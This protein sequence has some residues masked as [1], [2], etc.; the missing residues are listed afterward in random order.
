MPADDGPAG[1]APG[2]CHLDVLAAEFVE[3]RGAGDAGQQAHEGQGEGE[4]REGE[5]VEPGAQA[6][7]GAA[8]R[9]GEP[10]ELHGEDRDE[11][12]RGDEGRGGGGDARAD[13]HHPVE[14]TGAQG[15]EDAGA[16]SEDGDEEGRVADEEGGAG[17]PGAEERGDVLVVLGGAAEVSAQD[18]AEPGAV[19][20]HEGVVEVVFGAQGGD[21][22]GGRG[23]AVQQEGDGVSGGQVDGAEDHDGGHEHH[24]DESQEPAEEEAGHFCAAPIVAAQG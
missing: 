14:E 3:H 15:G 17:E 24:G 2:T 8:A 18:A 11:D 20:H 4:R 1:D 5:L 21:D 12:D 6:L 7:R 22:L 9:P 13:E 23:A 10:A 16:H 19:L